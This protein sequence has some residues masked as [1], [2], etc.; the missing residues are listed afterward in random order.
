MKPILLLVQISL[1]FGVLLGTA[2][3][4]IRIEA[5]DYI[6]MSGVQTEA[7]SEGGENIGYIN[8]GDWTQYTIDIPVAGDYQVDF[9]VATKNTGGTIDLVVG[10]YTVGSATVGYRVPGR[11]GPQPVQPRHSPTQAFKRCD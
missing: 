7:C 3:A 1:F 4:S 9:R 8:T 11:H 10:R 6:A 5:E 2:T